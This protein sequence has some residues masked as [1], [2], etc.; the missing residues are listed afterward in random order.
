MAND[1][2]RDSDRDNDIDSD[3][4]WISANDSDSA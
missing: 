1:S 3:S 2:E 4:D